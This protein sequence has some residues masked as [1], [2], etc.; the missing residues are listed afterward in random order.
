MVSLTLKRACIVAVFPCIV[1]GCGDGEEG[2]PVTGDPTL[3]TIDDGS[4][5]GSVAGDSVQFLGIPYAKPPV[6]ELRFRPPRAVDPW[7]NVRDA[8][9][10]GNRCAQLASAVLQNAA[11]NEEDCLYLNVWAPLEPSTTPRPV[12]VWIHGGGNVNGST[13]EPV[14]FVNTGLFYTGEFLAGKHDVVVV[15][16]NYRLGL[17]GFYAHP[18]LWDEDGSSGNQGLLDQQAALL[19]VRE[20]IAKFGG[21]PGNVTI[22]GESAGSLDVCLHMVAPSSR[23]LFHKAISQSGGC[24]TR[25]RTKTEG[26]EAALAFGATVGC[27]GT[28]ALPCLRAKS[29]AELMALPDVEA[30][31]GYGPFVDTLFIPDQPRTMFETNDFAKVPYLAG[32][33]ADEGTLFLPPAAMRP[34][35]ETEYLA[36]LNLLFG[37]TAAAEVAAVY[38]IANYATAMPN[39]AEAALARVIGD[40]R[41]VC[42]T[43]DSAVRAATKGAAV[44]MY[45]FDIPPPISLPGMYLGATHG[46]ELTSVFGTSPSF[47]TETRAASDLMQRYWTNFARTGDPNGGSDP[48]WPALTATANVRMNLTV[49]SAVVNNF[50]AAECAFWQ[51]RY[52]AQ[53]PP[54]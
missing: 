13:N 23:T 8:T 4:L 7:N 11:S 3:V 39:P 16:M 5:Q 45:N 18:N 25:M 40:S 52:A 42:T 36:S 54:P 22:F 38:P 49:Q 31:R 34:K 26:D 30:G 43:Y 21:D 46:A 41:L 48:Q 10:F 29:A 2:P 32:S 27:T 15:S 37:A 1:A 20:N 24:T 47:T 35:N 9:K 50:R 44:Y 19:W 6:G 14:P 17:F 53:F 33:N 28:D 12:M 51:Q